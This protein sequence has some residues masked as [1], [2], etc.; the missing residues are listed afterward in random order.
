MPAYGIVAAI[1][2]VIHTL[3]SIRPDSTP[4]V[5]GEGIGA[6]LV[7]TLLGVFSAY[8]IFSPIARTLEQNAAS[9][10]RPFEAVKEI[11]IAYKSAFSPRV[12]VEYGRKVLY[13]DQ[14]PSS[15]ELDIKVK[16]SGSNKS[17]D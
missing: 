4:G 12:A 8:A 9:D 6:A 1:V 5:I 14:R 3:S 13:T 15:K 17:D 16:S 2:G 10:V 11:L 7:G